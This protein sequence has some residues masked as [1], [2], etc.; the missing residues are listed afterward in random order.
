[1]MKRHNSIAGLLLMGSLLVFVPIAIAR[2]VQL[3]SIEELK[4]QADVV[5]IGSVAATEDAQG[6]TYEN[7]AADTWVKVDTVFQV[8]T[9]FKGKLEADTVAVRHERYFGQEAEVQVV[10]GPAFIAF[11]AEQKQRYLIFLKRTE[12]GTLEPLSGQYDP[13]FSFFRIGAAR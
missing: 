9:V 7:A 10:D 2:P 13:E 8:E 12:G 1:M 6:F 4:E 3:W 5:L 11:D